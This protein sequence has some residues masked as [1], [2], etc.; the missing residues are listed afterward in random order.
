M[1]RVKKNKRGIDNI[2]ALLRYTFPKLTRV[3]TP[4][5]ITVV[6]APMAEA[7][8]DHNMELS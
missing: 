3:F 7:T 8:D 1:L 5:H 4:S 6:S 2:F